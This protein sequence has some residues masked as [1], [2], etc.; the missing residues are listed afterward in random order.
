MTT[1]HTTDK[2]YQALY[3]EVTLDY[4]DFNG[5]YVFRLRDFSNS[6]TVVNS[7][8]VHVQKDAES[9]QVE[10]WHARMGHVGYRSLATLRD[11]STGIDFTNGTPNEECGPC[12]AVRGVVRLVSHLGL[13]C[14]SQQNF[15]LQSTVI[16]KD[17]F[18]ALDRGISFFE[19]S[20]G[21]VDIEPLKLKDDALT[22]FKSYKA[23]RE[24]QSDVHLK[25]LHTHRGGK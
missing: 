15:W 2:P 14:H 10:L 1:Y 8:K 18:F 5:L 21:L 12:K 11:L 25:V 22:A 7:T 17:L 13:P 6:T 16:W 4:A 20:T 3:N 24:K 9:G 19:E 23:L